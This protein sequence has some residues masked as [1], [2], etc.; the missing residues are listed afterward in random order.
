MTQAEKDMGGEIISEQVAARGP[1]L[2]L[3]VEG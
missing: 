3:R 2:K 1:T